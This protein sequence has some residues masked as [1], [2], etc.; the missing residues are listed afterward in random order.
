MNKK[1]IS[2]HLSNFYMY[3]KISVNL[4]FEKV[5]CARNNLRFVLSCRKDGVW[6]GR[7][8]KEILHVSFD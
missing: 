1:D 3:K 2:R 5:N 4:N 8:A 6:I 7:F